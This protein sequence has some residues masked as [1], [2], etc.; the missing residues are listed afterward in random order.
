MGQL[1]IPQIHPEI[2]IFQYPLLAHSSNEVKASINGLVTD[3]ATVNLSLTDQIQGIMYGQR[4]NGRCWQP[5]KTIPSA[6]PWLQS[7]E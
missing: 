1:T 2:P 7:L 5:Q 6:L 4:W 3:T